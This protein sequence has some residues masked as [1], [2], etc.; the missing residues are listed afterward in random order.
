[1]EPRRLAIVILAACL[2]TAVLGACASHAATTGSQ[3]TAGPIEEC[4]AFLKGYEHCLDSL[5]PTK[6]AQARVE[7]ARAGL[8]AQVGHGEAARAALQKQC[9]DNLSQLKATCR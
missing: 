9:A 2:T 8:A 4:E 5:G 7:Q 1:M 3:D 6:I